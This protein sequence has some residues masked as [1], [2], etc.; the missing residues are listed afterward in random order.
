MN[1]QKH[2]FQKSALVAALASGLLFAPAAQA[3]FGEDIWDAAKT[4]FTYVQAAANRFAETTGKLARGDIDGVANDLIEF[5]AGGK[6]F[7][8]LVDDM[9]R[10][11][12]Q[13]SL[14][15]A[16]HKAVE[17]SQR[18]E[19]GMIDTRRDLYRHTYETYKGDWKELRRRI[20]K[21]DL[22]FSEYRK[23]SLWY[24]IA[25]ADWGNPTKSIE[26][27]AYNQYEAFSWA[28]SH[29]PGK[30]GAIKFGA[31]R[32]MKDAAV[33]DMLAIMKDELRSNSIPSDVIGAILGK[34]TARATEDML[35][36]ARVCPAD[37]R[38]VGAW[39]GRSP[40]GQFGQTGPIEIRDQKWDE[41]IVSGFTHNNHEIYHYHPRSQHLNNGYWHLVSAD[42][43][44]SRSI[45]QQ[46]E[47]RGIYTSGCP[48][49]SYEFHLHNAK[50][51]GTLGAGEHVADNKLYHYDDRHADY[52]RWELLR[53]FD[54]EA[55]YRIIGYVLRD[56]KYRL[57]PAA[58]AAYNDEHVYH[59]LV[60]P[61]DAGSRKEAK[62]WLHL[63]DTCRD[64][65]A[66]SGRDLWP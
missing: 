37:F 36:L 18:I 13:N 64:G 45:R 60:T 51:G 48:G 39:E 55:D 42:D 32:A 11:L 16:A 17:V 47:A 65:D 46:F 56:L 3:W 8:G 50:H 38:R 31:Q 20:E 24:G 59:Q 34:M 57:G 35:A 2:H 40:W 5:Y 4:S 43:P 1:R 22:D 28:S 61:A 49:E 10:K 66:R 15:S 19:Q 52:N 41:A 63:C 44:L 62:W 25:H 7:M 54:Q 9:I 30:V 6:P 12:P 21:G 14:T 58:G 23:Y 33:R 27:I 29:K 26:E 53:V